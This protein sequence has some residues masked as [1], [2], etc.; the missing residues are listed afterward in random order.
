MSKVGKKYNL[1]P[2]QNFF[3]VLR[4]VAEPLGNLLMRQPVNKSQ[5]ASLSLPSGMDM[6]V[7]SFLHL[8]VCVHGAPPKKP[9]P[10]P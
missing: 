3:D 1:V 6:L 9:P 2:L 5:F 10:I 7:D 4:R 8:A